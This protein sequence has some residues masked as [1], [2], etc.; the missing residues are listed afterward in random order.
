MDAGSFPCQSPEQPQALIAGFVVA[1]LVGLTTAAQAAFVAPALWSREQANTTYQEWNVFSSPA[2]PNMPDIGWL[3]PNG[4][5]DLFDTSGGSFVTG[6]GNIY[7]PTSVLDLRVVVPDYARTGDVTTVILQT[8]TNGSEIDF[9][10]V[11]IGGT[12]FE[13]RGELLRQPLGGF[14]GFAVETWLKFELPYSAS[15]FTVEFKASGTSMS[16]DRVAVDTITASSFV[17]EPN[18]VPEPLT[19]VLLASGL[20][21]LASRRRA[22]HIASIVRA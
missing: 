17:P 5:P 13:D 3:N 1:L 7:S 11:R 9:D 21:R 10:T 6:S 4:T 19:G 2:G 8:R 14:G 20:L 22:P 18:P 15:S 16:L 12:G